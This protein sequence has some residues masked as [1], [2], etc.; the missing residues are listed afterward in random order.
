MIINY[1]GS[2]GRSATGC[3]HAYPEPHEAARRTGGCEKGRL[4]GGGKEH[5]KDLPRAGRHCRTGC[6]GRRRS[7]ASSERRAEARSPPPRRS[8]QLQGVGHIYGGERDGKVVR[9]VRDVAYEAAVYFQDVQREALQVGKRGNPVPKSSI[10]SLT[11][12]SFRDSGLHGLL[13]V[14]SAPSSAPAPKG[15][16]PGPLREHP[17]TAS[18]R[19]FF[20]KC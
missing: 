16:G 14:A 19:S 15:P 8:L 6:P 18:K 2:L 7:R 11:P 3:Q 20:W 9:I 5:V 4:S 17:V 10:A 12:I 13:R 1:A